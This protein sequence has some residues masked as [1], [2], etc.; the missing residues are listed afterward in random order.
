MDLRQHGIF[1]LG[2]WQVAHVRRAGSQAGT[3]VAPLVQVRA[4]S[5]G[6]A[7]H[8]SFDEGATSALAIRRKQKS[9]QQQCRMLGSVFARCLLSPFN[10]GVHPSHNS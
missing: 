8:F 7:D 1:D 3:G 6:T 4:R 10:E 9:R 5:S 2:G